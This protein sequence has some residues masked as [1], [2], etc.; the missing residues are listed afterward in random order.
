MAYGVY[1]G[2]D[3]RGNYS[4]N[5]VTSNSYTSAYDQAAQPNRIGQTSPAFSPGTE[6]GGGESGLSSAGIWGAII[7]A[8]G[9]NMNERQ[10]AMAGE[11]AARNA[12]PVDPSYLQPFLRQMAAEGKQLASSELGARPKAEAAT[13]G[14]RSATA[15]GLSGPLAASVQAESVGRASDKYNQWRTA[16]LQNYRQ[17]YM[18]RLSQYMQALEARRQ[19]QVRAG[20][21]E[22][23]ARIA[24]NP[25]LMGPIGQGIA[26][27]ALDNNWTPFSDLYASNIE[28]RGAYTRPDFE[29]F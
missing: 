21:A 11:A 5:P 6:H 16:A 2:V 27:I 22:R 8:V 28:K 18:D 10:K 7:G 12:I 26:R 25:L 15:R 13:A 3:P 19:A 14:H 24:Q 17:A 4:A 20:Y 1:P 29:S 23:E 9:Q